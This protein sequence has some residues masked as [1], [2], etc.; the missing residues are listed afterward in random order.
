MAIAILAQGE[1]LESSGGVLRPTCKHQ[2]KA[3]TCKAQ[4]TNWSIA[5]L[6][7]LVGGALL[8]DSLD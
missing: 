5:L 6:C 3:S 1:S 7:G 4:Q 8:P 2:K